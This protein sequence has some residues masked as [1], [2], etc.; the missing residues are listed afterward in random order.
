MSTNERS[1][2]FVQQLNATV[3]AVSAAPALEMR[4]GDG[5]SGHWDISYFMPS[6]KSSRPSDGVISATA[7]KNIGESDFSVRGAVGLDD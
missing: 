4:P 1:R 3:H 2:H 5:R 6:T 7:C